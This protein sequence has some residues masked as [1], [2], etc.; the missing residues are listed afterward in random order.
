MGDVLTDGGAS[1]VSYGP[2][3]IMVVGLVWAFLRESNRREE[4]REA[5]R[6]ELAAERKLNAEL[7]ALRIAEQ[8]ENL[9]LAQLVRTTLE[10]T[11]TA[12]KGGRT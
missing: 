3:G 2:L 7:Q 10:S 5:H 8:R 6:I 12:L 11:L 1:L 4:E 9:E